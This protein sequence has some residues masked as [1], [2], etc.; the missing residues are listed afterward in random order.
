MALKPR[1]HNLAYVHRDKGYRWVDR[2]PDM[3]ELCDIIDKLGMSNGDIIDKVLDAS[4]GSVAMSWQ[5]IENWRNGKTRKPSNFT[6]KWV[7]YALGYE[8]SWRKF[9]Q[10]A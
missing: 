8:R 2:D 7:G 5:T 3:I 4:G 1:A 9:R 10:S 6:L